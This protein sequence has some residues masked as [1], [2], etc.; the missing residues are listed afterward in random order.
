MEAYIKKKQ[1]DNESK[2]YLDKIMKSRNNNG[3][4]TFLSSSKVSKSNNHAQRYPVYDQED[5][6]GM[7]RERP[8]GQLGMDLNKV[9]KCAYNA[10]DGRN[11]I[12]HKTLNFPK[13]SRN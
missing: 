12:I 13:R 9:L 7:I 10:H 1:K 6:L 2:L 4:L 3:V 5:K 8:D 11:N